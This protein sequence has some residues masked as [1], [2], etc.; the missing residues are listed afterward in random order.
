MFHE[1]F[2]KRGRACAN[3]LSPQLVDVAIVI[4]TMGGRLALDA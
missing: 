4:A 3:I 1:S 2:A